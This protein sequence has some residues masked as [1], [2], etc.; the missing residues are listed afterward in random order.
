MSHRVEVIGKPGCHLCVDAELV[1]ERVCSELGVQWRKR[2]ILEE[3]ELAD[4][5]AEQIPV[6]LVDGEVLS[7]WHVYEAPLRKALL[8]P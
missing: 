1:V 3:P 2:S 7:Y 4:A 8:A 5:Y 6:I